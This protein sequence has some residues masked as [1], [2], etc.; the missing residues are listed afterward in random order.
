MDRITS[1]ATF[2]KVVEHAGFSAAAR[3]LGMSPSAATTHVQALEDR[4]RVRL[5]NRSTRKL[6]LTEVGEAY[7]HRCVQILSELDDA[8]E[9]AQ[10]LH[11]VA[12]G[13]LR[14]NTSVAVPPIIA[15]V[16][17]DFVR[18]NPE[19]SV[20]MAMTDRMVDVVEEGY[21]LAVRNMPVA[22]ST[23][24]ARHIAPFRLVVCGTPQYFAEHGTPQRPEDVKAHNCLSYLQMLR[25]DEW[26]FV[27]LDGRAQAVPVS[28]NLRSN[29]AL[30]LC[31]AVLQGQGILYTSSF[32]VADS[33]RSGHLVTVLD[34]YLRTEY[35]IQA[36]YPHR[37]HLSAK[38]R[39]FI[40]MLVR[41]FR[42]HPLCFECD[43]AA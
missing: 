40:D 21:D 32:I 15:P 8:D 38:V 24:I 22:D 3:A 31:A 10:A 29:S 19:V 33:L 9:I 14:L 35:Y 12:R 36:I 13:R 2:V 34:D 6:S 4:L 42:D 28:G 39:T 18:L 5:L 26:Q 23:L 20:D 1:M 25:R 37:H 41:H 16:V 30:A 11:S 43:K 27:G 17:A 7:Y